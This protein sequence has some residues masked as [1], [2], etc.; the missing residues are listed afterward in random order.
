MAPAASKPIIPQ[1]DNVAHAL[2]GAGGG[3][4]SMILTY[5]LITLSTRAQV[6]STRGETP[7][8][9][10]VR[11]IIAR[12]GV[13][14]L[15]A[16][17]DSA[18]FGISV[19]NFVYYYWYEWTR[20]FFEAAAVKA[21]RASSKLTTVESMIAG[22]LAG[23]ATVI[24]TNPIWVVNTRMT[25]RK[26][27][28]EEEKGAGQPGAEK[29]RSPTTIGTLLALLKEEG[30]QALFRGVVPALVLVI[31]PILQ[32]TLFEQ[33]KNVVEKKR[34]ITP[35]VAFVLG[36]LGKLFATSITY[37]YITVKSQMHVAGNG[38]REG[39]G[40]AIN[41]VIKEEGYKGLYKGIAPKV[42]Q[43]VLTAAFLFAFK[44]VLYEQTVRLRGTAAK[45]ALA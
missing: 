33:M 32:Y 11:R 17:L 44:D 36:A 2:A 1:N 7:F 40:Q 18:V 14:G 20:A 3:V 31:N 16:G 26:Q 24:L 42:T 12:E 38:Q 34:R 45:K 4:L 29:K 39:M 27:D 22:A 8:L 10:A 23:S 43:S 37:P 19:T 25:T 15:Y 30:P 5:P 41:R 35:G 9:T 6:E 13:S 28:I 21:G